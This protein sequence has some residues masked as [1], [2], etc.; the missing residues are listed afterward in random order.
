MRTASQRCA[1]MGGKATEASR[2]T[3]ISV[4]VDASRFA[5]ADSNGDMQLEWEEFL[6]LQPQHV[7]ERHSLSE[8]R[9]W[10]V[11]ADLNKNG[12][13]SINEFFSWTLAKQ[14]RDGGEGLRDLFAAYD[15]DSTGYIDAQEFQRVADDLGFGAAAYEIFHDL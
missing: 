15:K 3:K 9:E 14:I 13:V 5:E 8:I 1:S 11:A 4:Q 10:F 12:T 7:R 2:R 6:S